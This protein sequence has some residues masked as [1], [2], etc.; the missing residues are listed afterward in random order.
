M[1]NVVLAQGLTFKTTLL[2]VPWDFCGCFLP[3]L[4][5]DVLF[6]ISEKEL[7]RHFLMPMSSY[8]SRIYFGLLCPWLRY[9]GA[10]RLRKL[11]V[12]S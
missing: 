10:F 12:A 3:L 1:V 8:P 5:P 4:R 7:F 6:C 11:V 2:S 9:L